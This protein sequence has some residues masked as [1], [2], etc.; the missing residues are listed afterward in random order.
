MSAVVVPDFGG[1]V[2]MER[3]QPCIVGDYREGMM[4]CKGARADMQDAGSA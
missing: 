1:F 2:S 3:S 4:Q